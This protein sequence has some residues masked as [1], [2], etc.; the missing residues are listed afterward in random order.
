MKPPDLSPDPPPE[1]E[2][3]PISFRSDSTAR[4]TGL[5]TPVKWLVGSILFFTFI[6]LAGAAWFV[7]TAKRVVIEISP[8][9]DRLSLDGGI[10]TPRF[11]KDYLLRPGNTRCGP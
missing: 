4:R 1:I 3:E 9:P 11:G 8:E 6:V 5:S 2:I 10:I 7:F